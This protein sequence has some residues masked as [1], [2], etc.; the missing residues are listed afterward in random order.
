MLVKVK[1]QQ[2]ISNIS[3][4]QRVVNSDSA[5]QRTDNI[6]AG[7]RFLKTAKAEDSQPTLRK[8]KDPSQ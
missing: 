5:S 8:I 3:E 1:K 2:I 4:G 7:Y 6:D